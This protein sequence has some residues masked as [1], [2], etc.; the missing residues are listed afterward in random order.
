MVAYLAT[1]DNP[2]KYEYSGCGIRFNACSQF[3]WSDHSW[4][5]NIVIVGVDN[6][7]SVHIDNE[8][9]IF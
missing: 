1:S 4:G 8:K 6:S 2:N 5:E 7:Y 9:N 3:S